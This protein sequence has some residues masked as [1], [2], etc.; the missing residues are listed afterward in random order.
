MTQNNDQH[1]DIL[2]TSEN[3]DRCSLDIR[4]ETEKLSLMKRKRQCITVGDDDNVDTNH[5]EQIPDQTY[6]SGEEI[7]V[8]FVDPAH[9]DVLQSQTEDASVAWPESFIIRRVPAIPNLLSLAEV[10]C[11]LRGAFKAPRGVHRRPTRG[12]APVIPDGGQVRSCA[13]AL[14]EHSCIS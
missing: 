4:S 8:D 1:H 10:D 9:F 6:I 14:A 7:E 2:H 5:C 11:V 3:S 13:G 12:E